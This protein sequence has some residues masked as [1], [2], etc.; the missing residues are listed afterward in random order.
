MKKI[1]RLKKNHDIASVVGKRK[2]IVSP[3]CI[4]YYDSSDKVYTR[5]AISV[6]CKYGNAVERNLAKRRVRTILHPIIKH[7]GG[8]NLVVVIR[9]PFKNAQYSVLQ[10]EILSMIQKI[11]LKFKEKINENKN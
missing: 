5:C 3:F 4:I 7:I 2:K 6:S 9:I 11:Y 10:K 1:N 8:V